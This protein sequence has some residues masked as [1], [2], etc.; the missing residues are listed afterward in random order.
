MLD[1]L[2]SVIF[3]SSIENSIGLG[4]LKHVKRVQDSWVIER[5][6]EWVAGWKWVLLGLCRE[7]SEVMWTM[8]DFC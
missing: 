5:E 4:V 2:G 1:V 6:R 3:Y 7:W 8:K